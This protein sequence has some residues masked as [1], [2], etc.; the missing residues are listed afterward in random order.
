MRFR[1]GSYPRS[2]ARG[3]L[4]RGTAR[5]TRVLPCRPGTVPNATTAATRHLSRHSR[6][7]SLHAALA[8]KLPRVTRLKLHTTA[9]TLILTPG[10]TAA[11]SSMA[12]DI[13]RVYSDLTHAV[14]LTHGRSLTHRASHI[15]TTPLTPVGA[16]TR[17][18]SSTQGGSHTRAAS[19]AHVVSSPCGAPFT[20]GMPGNTH[21]GTLATTPLAHGASSRV[22]HGV[23]S[24]HEAS[25]PPLSLATCMCVCVCVRL[26]LLLPRAVSPLPFPASLS[27][28]S[29]RS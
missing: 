17:G 1:T 6:S 10:D 19:R 18:V 12:T 26:R 15:L 5:T 4:V 11:C 21:S 22:S 25:S 24:S 20:H 13:S 14:T 16:L 27:A 29:P 23:S 28:R 9:F 2:R 8:L 3:G 7:R